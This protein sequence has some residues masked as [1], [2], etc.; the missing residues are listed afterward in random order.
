MA[1]PMNSRIRQIGDPI[2]R[3]ISSAIAVS[4][5]ANADI[6]A[7]IDHMQSI[8]NGIK[9]IS[10]ENG[11]AL[12]APQVG[13]PIRLILLRINGEFCAMINPEFTP[14]SDE[15]FEFEEECFSLYDKRAMIMRYRHINLT[16]RDRNG[17][18]QS[19][20]LSGEEAALVQHEIDHLDGVL[21][22]DHVGQDQLHDIETVLAKDPKRL[23]QV[24]DMMAYMVAKA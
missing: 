16:Y 18:T 6:Q 23:S 17:D 5:V 1:K 20:H 2:L 12:S 24:K 13:R 8:L 15:K 7:L 9:S 19:K 3:Q 21:F 11:N 22:V 14:L 10:E 4:E